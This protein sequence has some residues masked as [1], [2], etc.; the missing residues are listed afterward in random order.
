MQYHT[1]WYNISSTI[2]TSKIILI[3]KTG[4]FKIYYITD[5]ILHILYITD[6]FTYLL[7]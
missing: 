4:K 2:K 3:V 1:F 6:L 7:T 5:Y